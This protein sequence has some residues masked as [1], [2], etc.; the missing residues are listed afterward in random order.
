MSY[1]HHSIASLDTFN[2]NVGQYLNTRLI[3]QYMLHVANTPKTQISLS[4]L[5]L[6]QQLTKDVINSR[7]S[8]Y[9]Q[10]AHH[11]DK[12]NLILQN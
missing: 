10:N 2:C 9:D 6:T 3:L 12:H 4:S 5:V 7:K 8:K 1:S 11:K